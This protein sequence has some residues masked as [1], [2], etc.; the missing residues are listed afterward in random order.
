[1]DEEASLM[2]SVQLSASLEVGEGLCPL[3]E[4]FPPPWVLPCSPPSYLQSHQRPLVKP[5]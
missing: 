1:M 2:A 4:Q 3:G 5:E